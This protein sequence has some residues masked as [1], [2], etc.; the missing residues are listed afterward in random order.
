MHVFVGILAYL[1]E[2]LDLTLQ[3]DSNLDK[4]DSNLAETQEEY[5]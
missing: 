3:L 1:Q 2:Q 5:E 4:T